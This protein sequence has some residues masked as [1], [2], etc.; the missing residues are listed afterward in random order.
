MELSG[1]NSL[2]E[3]LAMGGHAAYIWPAL[4]VAAAVVLGA[5]AVGVAVALRPEA[6]PRL[7]GNFDPP[8]IQGRVEGVTP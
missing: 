1:M 8:R 2:G 7:D 3:F 4:G 5:V 6:D